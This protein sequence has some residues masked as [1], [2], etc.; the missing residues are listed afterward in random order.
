M[1]LTAAVVV[2]VVVVA[3]CSGATEHFL[4]GDLK[5][6]DDGSFHYCLACPVLH[7]NFLENESR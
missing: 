7:G 2:V 6:M 4:Y 3:H 5:I 1:Y